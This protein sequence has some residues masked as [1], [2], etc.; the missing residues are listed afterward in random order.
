MFMGSD[1]LA[2]DHRRCWPAEA[3]RKTTEM[4]ATAVHSEASHVRR[5]PARCA[6]P[7]R[8]QITKA[9]RR[10]RPIRDRSRQATSWMAQP[11]KN[12]TVVVHAGGG[13]PNAGR[14]SRSKTSYIAITFNVSNNRKSSCRIGGQILAYS[15]CIH[16][17][18]SC[19]CAPNE[20]PLVINTSME[21]EAPHST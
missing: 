21:T 4:D 17:R 3:A 12:Q 15:S 6:P 7:I 20:Y 9:A 19:E 11:M 16:P 14:I 18:Y 10:K 1:R 8:K 5:T 13:H 2:L